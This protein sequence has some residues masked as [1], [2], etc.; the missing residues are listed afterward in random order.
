MAA[1]VLGTPSNIDGGSTYAAEAGSNRIVVIC[2]ARE[3]AATGV[4]PTV[5]T[6]SYGTPSL[7]NGQIVQAV[8]A[9]QTA[10]NRIR[11]TVWYVLEA[12]IPVG[13]QTVA[14]TWSTAMNGADKFTLYTLGGVDQADPI[15]NTATVI[16]GG[17]ALNGTIAVA[18]NTLQ[19]SSLGNNT[20][21]LATPEGTFIEIQDANDGGGTA[22]VYSHYN[23]QVAAATI[24]WGINLTQTGAGAV[25]SFNSA[26]L[27]SIAP[28]AAY[29]RM[30][31]RA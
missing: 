10:N 6:L 5:S 26:A 17:G 30:M 21:A 1:Q 31:N 2:L 27:T 29:Y 20:N 24:N 16:Q 11:A 22:R 19:V 7:A 14:A 15:D 18:D 13:A 23:V 8:T 4:T 28:H 12:N 9:V 25:A 3:P